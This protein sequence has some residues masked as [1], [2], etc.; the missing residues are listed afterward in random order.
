M[1]QGLTLTNRI[2]EDGFLVRDRV[3]PDHRVN[4]ADAFS[5]DLPR[6]SFC[7]FYKVDVAMLRL[8]AVEPFRELRAESPI[9]LGGVAK[10]GVTTGWGTLEQ[11]EENQAR[12]L[13]VHTAI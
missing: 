1:I 4:T 6:G 2:Y 12:R 7:S 9:K 10:Y 3:R 13:W 8:Q 11:I 5:F